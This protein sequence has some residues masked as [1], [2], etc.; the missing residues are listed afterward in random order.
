MVTK[1][2]KIL[3]L[4]AFKKKKKF[5]NVLSTYGSKKN[6]VSG[7]LICELIRICYQNNL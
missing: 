3:E 1:M 7:E 2:K 5:I 4:Q 6:N